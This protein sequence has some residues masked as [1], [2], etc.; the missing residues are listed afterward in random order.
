MENNVIS[1]S[2]WLINKTEKYIQ[3]NE[4]TKAKDCLKKSP[5]YINN[6]DKNEF[7][8]SLSII[9]ELFLTLNEPGLAIICLRE[10]INA[11]PQLTRNHYILG[12]AYASLNK[13][14]LALKCFKIAYKKKPGNSEYLRCIGWI[15]LTLNKIKKGQYYLKKSLELDNE[16]IWSLLDLG[17]S[18]I[19]SYD[20]DSAIKYFK[21]A[22]N[23]FKDLPL[24]SNG[25]KKAIKLNEMNLNLED[26]KYKILNYLQDKVDKVSFKDAIEI[27]LYISMSNFGYHVFQIQGA[28]SIWE[29]F[30]NL[31]EKNLKSFDIN[32]YSAAMQYTFCKIDSLSKEKLKDIATRYN[33]S[34]RNILKIYHSIAKILKLS[35]YDP[36]YSTNYLISNI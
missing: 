22:K 36:R 29:D 4:F 7:S 23:I 18:Y 17:Y 32:L 6:K 14:Q 1:I 34:A 12:F 15:Y 10:S 31:C 8:N 35:Y 13:P 11:L 2:N 27:N 19:H 25:L 3:K 33:V 16:N 9:G 26:K 24:V 28:C 21:Q 30:Y 20:F 5:L